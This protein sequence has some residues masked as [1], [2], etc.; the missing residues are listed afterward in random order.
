[1][2]GADR[3]AGPSKTENECDESSVSV[4]DLGRMFTSLRY[5]AKMRSANEKMQAKLALTFSPNL[6]E[7]DI[8][9]YTTAIKC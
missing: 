2:T 9:K 8:Q 6:A 5:T 1:M 4:Q 3:V 7:V